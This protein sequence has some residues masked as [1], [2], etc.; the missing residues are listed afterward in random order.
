[1]EVLSLWLFARQ[2]QVLFAGFGVRIPVGPVVAITYSRSAISMTFPAGSVVSAVFAIDQF[3][4]LGASRSTAAT[5]TVLSGMVSAAGFGCLYGAGA[6][7]VWLFPHSWQVVAAVAGALCATY[8]AVALAHR[9]PLGYRLLS[10]W[11]VIPIGLVTW[12]VRTRIR[13]SPSSNWPAVQRDS[14]PL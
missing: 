2:Q 13:V 14:P 6:V 1:M 10:C 7:A 8:L 4:R 12:L 11:L 3:H 9:R 5:V